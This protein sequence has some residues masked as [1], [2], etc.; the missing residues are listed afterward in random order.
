VL[1]LL[2]QWWTPPLRLQASACSTF[3]MVCY[4]PSMAVFLRNLLSVVLVFFTHI[5]VNFCL[6]FR[7]P[8]WLLVW[9]SISCSTFS[10]FLYLDFY[11]LISL[12][13]PIVLHSYL[14]VLLHQS[15][16][17]FCPCCF[18]LLCLACLPKPLYPFVSIDS[19][20]QLHLYVQLLA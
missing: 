8:Q 1:L 20:K 2:N 17:R 3:L 10:E 16:S 4:V 6:Q 14:M 18:W 5:F 19:I 12:Q 13:L 11:T 7:W 15:I 9:Q